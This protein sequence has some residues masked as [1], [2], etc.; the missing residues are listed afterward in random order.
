MRAIPVLLSCLTLSLAAV[1]PASATTY[2]VSQSIGAAGSVTGT[3]D[4][5]G[6][7]GALSVG[8]FTGWTLLVT[9]GSGATTTLTN[10]NSAVYIAGAAATATASDILFDYSNAVASYLL[11]QAGGFGTGNTYWCNSSASGAC[12]QGATATPGFTFDGTRQDEARRG[13][14]SIASAAGDAGAVPEPATWAMFIGGFGLV[15]AAMRRR[16]SVRVAFA[17]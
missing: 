15:G 6:A 17:G 16:Q 4:T 11:F 12:L 9:G 10:L 14:Q 5:N 1:A 7:T 8:D 2:V 13:V 3:I